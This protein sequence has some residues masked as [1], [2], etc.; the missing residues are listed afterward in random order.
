MKRLLDCLP[1]N[2]NRQ[3]KRAPIIWPL[4][5]VWAN[6]RWW[7]L[8]AEA[9]C[10]LRRPNWP[11]HVLWPQPQRAVITGTTGYPG[12]VRELIKTQRSNFSG[13]KHHRQGVDGDA[14]FVWQYSARRSTQTAQMIP[15]WQWPGFLMQQARDAWPPPATW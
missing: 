15:C 13:H 2:R 5:C 6:V 11:G 4:P 7:P 3:R 9:A 14:I 1:P 8:P 12:P 10:K